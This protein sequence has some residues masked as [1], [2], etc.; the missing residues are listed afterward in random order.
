MNIH[1]EEAK[2][3]VNWTVNNRY[4]PTHNSATEQR[5]SE[6]NK[7]TEINDSLPKKGKWLLSGNNGG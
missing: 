2:W 7:E 4:I 3:D 1:F 6:E 5:R